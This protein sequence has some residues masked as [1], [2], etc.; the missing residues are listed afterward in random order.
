M[1]Y[2]AYVCLGNIQIA[3]MLIAAQI[4]NLIKHP[5]EWRALFLSAGMLGIYLSFIIIGFL[6]IRKHQSFFLGFYT[7]ALSLLLLQLSTFTT[8]IDQISVILESGGV[9]ALFLIGPF[10]FHLFSGR[11]QNRTSYQYYVQLLPAILAAI[12]FQKKALYIFPW[13]YTAGMLHIG[14]YLFFQSWQIFRKEEV[15]SNSR[16]KKSGTRNWNKKYTGIQIAVY[17]LSGLA[18]VS[19]SL[20][21]DHFIASSGLAILILITWI[22]LMHTAIKQYIK[23]ID[24]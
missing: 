22:R 23:I 1:K 3:E 12:L 21:Q 19:P 16:Q 4:E 8:P 15:N 14:T 20:Q 7:A 2:S 13:I 5:E 6:R 24:K 9:G 10:S 18:L 17:T 11:V